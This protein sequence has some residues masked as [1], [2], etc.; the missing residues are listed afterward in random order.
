VPEQY[1]RTPNTKCLICSKEIY[2]R[3]V[4]IKRGRVFCGQVCY[5]IAN[6]KESP[7]VV[8]GKSIMSSLNKKT[9]SRACSNKYR[10]GIKYK[11]GR[12]RDKA[13]TAH[14][15]KLRLLEKRAKKCERCDYDK[16]EILQIHHKDRARN[17]NNLENLELICPN[18][19][20]EEHYSQ[21]KERWEQMELSWKSRVI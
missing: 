12:P 6:R 1:K 5:G 9:C 16:V 13:V 4:E 3:P 17:N 11:I 14:L 7:C 15:L 8:C 21:H 10:E 19:H 20:Y 18:C 2:R